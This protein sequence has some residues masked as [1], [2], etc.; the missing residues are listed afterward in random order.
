MA[1]EEHGNPGWAHGRE[2]SEELTIAVAVKDCSQSL[3]YL[4]FLG[5]QRNAV[6]DRMGKN[7]PDELQVDPITTVRLYSLCK[8]LSPILKEDKLHIPQNSWHLYLQIVI[9]VQNLQS[10]RVT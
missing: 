2:E 3:C 8:T 10:K 9:Q 6:I 5:L 4:Y 1:C 7:I